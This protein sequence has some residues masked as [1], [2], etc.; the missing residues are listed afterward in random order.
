[1]KKSIIESELLDNLLVLSS[2]FELDESDL[3]VLANLDRNVRK[4]VPIV[5]LADGSGVEIR[6][7]HSK[8]FPFAEEETEECLKK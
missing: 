5:T 8:Y 6:D 7:L 1:M 4:I 2:P 3:S